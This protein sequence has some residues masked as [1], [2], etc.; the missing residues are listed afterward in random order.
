MNIKTKFLHSTTYKS[1]RVSVTIDGQRKEFS[2]DYADNQD[3]NHFKAIMYAIKELKRG[4]KYDFEFNRAWKRGDVI[5]TDTG[6]TVT[7]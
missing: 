6:Y 2:W 7:L 3:V 1:D 4:I 5:S